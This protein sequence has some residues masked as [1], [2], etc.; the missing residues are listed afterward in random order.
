MVSNITLV[1]VEESEVDNDNLSDED[2]PSTRVVKYHL[3][4]DF[5]R[6]KT[7]GL[8]LQ[9]SIGEKPIEKMLMVE[10]HYFRGK[11]IREYSFEFGFVIP[12]S[13]N[14]WEFIYD[15]PQLTEEEMA[16]IV[17]APWEL[18]SDS[19]FFCNG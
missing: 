1:E 11:V 9:F 16:E 13:T 7:V 12:N 4:P 15:L 6:L 2:D 10:R 14:T 17:A 8:T 19:F 18:K 5:L 3:G